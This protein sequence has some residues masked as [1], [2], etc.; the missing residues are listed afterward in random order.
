MAPAKD[1]KRCASRST[2]PHDPRILN[3]QCGTWEGHSS[4]LRPVRTVKAATAVDCFKGFVAFYQLID[5]EAKTLLNNKL[6]KYIDILSRTLPEYRHVHKRCSSHI[7]MTEQTRFALTPWHS[8][9][10]A[11]Y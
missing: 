6:N 5:G 4:Q 8:M 3:I 10:V 9:C 1:S 11:P 2:G 7:R